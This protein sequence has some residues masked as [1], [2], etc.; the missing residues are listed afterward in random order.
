M[1]KR[2]T[3]EYIPGGEGPSHHQASAQP[4]AAVLVE[5]S[6]QNR[7][8]YKWLARESFAGE[9]ALTSGMRGGR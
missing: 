8:F 4:L 9:H 6:R 2:G 5:K 3:R 1:A 7:K